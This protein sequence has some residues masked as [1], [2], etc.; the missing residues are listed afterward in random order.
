MF[1]KIAQKVSIHLG[2]FCMKFF[3]RERLKIAQSGHTGCPLKLHTRAEAIV[4]PFKVAGE[5]KI[6]NSFCV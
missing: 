4:I 6:T 1:Y 2:Y 5:T 3:Y